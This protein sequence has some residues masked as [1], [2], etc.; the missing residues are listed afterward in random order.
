VLSVALAVVAD[1]FFV[2]LE[3]RVT[4]WSRARQA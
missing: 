3:K 1:L 4:P 2:Q